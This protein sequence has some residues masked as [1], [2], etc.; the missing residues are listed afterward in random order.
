MLKNSNLGLSSCVPASRVTDARRQWTLIGV[1]FF[2]P[3]RC[4]MQATQPPGKKL[5]RNPHQSC[6]EIHLRGKRLSSLAFPRAFPLAATLFS[7]I[8]DSP[9]NL[10]SSTNRLIADL[11]FPRQPP[12]EM[13]NEVHAGQSHHSGSQYSPSRKRTGDT[14][15]RNPG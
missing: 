11:N 5:P 4:L 9:A 7:P 15:P 10:G 6:K 12:N 3:H 2:G 1:A 14:E 8:D 13:H